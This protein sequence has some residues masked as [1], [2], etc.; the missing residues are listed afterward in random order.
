MRGPRGEKRP[1]DAIS[2]A[3]MVA[4][5]ATSEEE[6]TRYEQLNR[7]KGRQTG[8][9]ARAEKLTAE[10]RKEIAQKGV[11]ARLIQAF[12][13]PGRSPLVVLAGRTLAGHCGAVRQRDRRLPRRKPSLRSHRLTRPLVFRHPTCPGLHRGCLGHRRLQLLPAR[14]VLSHP[15]AQKT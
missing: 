7:V 11:K 5:I 14:L 3:V 2:R 12:Q 6:D 8:G 10:E 15:G 4:R 1:A 9:R 13:T